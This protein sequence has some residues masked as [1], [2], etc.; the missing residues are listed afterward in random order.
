MYIEDDMGTIETEGERNAPHIISLVSTFDMRKALRLS[1]HVGI[2]CANKCEA[3][4]DDDD[5]DDD[6]A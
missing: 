2:S 1:L 5:D 4:D 6:M 3:I